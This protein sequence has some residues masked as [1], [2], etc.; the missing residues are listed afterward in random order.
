MSSGQETAE[1]ACSQYAN[2]V[3]TLEESDEL[4]HALETWSDATAQY[5]ASSGR[6]GQLTLSG[7][8]AKFRMKPVLV[9]LSCHLDASSLKVEVTL[10]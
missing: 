8:L 10:I 4:G 7:K 6:V 1:A 3:G 9:R 5:W 2:A